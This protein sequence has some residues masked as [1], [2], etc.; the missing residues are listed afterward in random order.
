MKFHLV[1]E[2]TFYFKG[3]IMYNWILDE[4]TELSEFVFFALKN[5]SISN[6]ETEFFKKK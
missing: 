3:Q 2:S 6:K 4:I 1:D 5:H